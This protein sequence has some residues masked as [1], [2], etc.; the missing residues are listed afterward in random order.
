MSAPLLRIAALQPSISIT[1][2]RLGALDHLVACTRWCLDALPELRS[3]SLH[4]ISD[5]WSST[6]DEIVATRAGLVIA[7]VPYRMESLAAILKAG[8]PVL[9]LAPRRLVDV[10]AD[11]RLLG[12][13]VHRSEAAETCIR[14]MQSAVET[15]RSRASA[16]PNRPLVYA[17]EWGK[18]LIH[19]QPWVAE[20]IDAAGGQ[21]LGTPGAVTDAQA[22]AAADPDAMIF[23]WCGAGSRVPLERIAA[24]RDWSTLA[25][26]RSR[27]LYC[28]PDELLN[29]P[30][31]SLIDGLHALAS[32]LHPEIF[33]ESAL[34]RRIRPV[35]T[36][37]PPI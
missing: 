10:Y 31:P 1:L 36:P 8:L 2:A 35:P 24:L 16:A 6:A 11:I 14:E 23:A 33:G 19:S 21:F 34:A 30:A 26:V 37:L 22:I 13:V 17:E 5:S 3:R 32:A 28:L 27:R 12:S 4:V 20:L 7:A 9:A 25:A 18:P 29:T 15:V